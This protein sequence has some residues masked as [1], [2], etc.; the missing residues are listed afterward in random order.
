MSSSLLID[1]PPLQVQP[2]LA[3]L[4]GLNEAIF[5]QQVHYWLNPRFNQNLIEGRRWVH[6][7]LPQWQKQFPFWGEKTL[8][9]TIV[10]L[11]DLGVLESY[12]KRNTFRKTKFYS[13]NYDVLETRKTAGSDPSGQN[14]QTD[15]PKGADV[16]GQSDRIDLVNMTR[17][18]TYTETTSETSSSLSFDEEKEEDQNLIQKLVGVWDEVIQTPLGAR[19]VTMTE[20][21]CQDL[22]RLFASQFS[23]DF[24]EWESYCHKIAGN[25]FLMGGNESGFKVS[26]DWALR[27]QNAIK[28]LEGAIYSKPQP[29]ML[30]DL[31]WDQFKEKL[32]AEH[33]VAGHPELWTKVCVR[34]AK[35][36]TQAT[37]MAWIQPL[38]SVVLSSDEVSLK[39]PN[40]Y[41]CDHV[42][43]EYSS[44]IRK[45][46]HEEGLEIP[47]LR[48]SV[49]G[50]IA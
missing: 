37:F 50:G 23:S 9:R 5:L 45:A 10:N 7:T 16:C 42:I 24:S 20:D 8:R 18:Y 41:L 39:A 49:Q 33:K 26:F 31:P 47:T 44:F 13:I 15:L 48:I 2:T 19:P 28:I 11:E 12:V 6:N 27:P 1:E 46:F 30:R 32:S 34:L 35:K 25:S 21:R 4:I 29:T 36:L 3:V 38:T 14:D 22:R 43:S 40:Q 17:L